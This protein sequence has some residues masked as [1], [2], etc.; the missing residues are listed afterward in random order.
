[1][2]P[3]KKQDGWFVNTKPTALFYFRRRTRAPPE[4]EMKPTKPTFLPTAW[5]FY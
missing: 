3:T 2:T 1:M 4:P 5:S